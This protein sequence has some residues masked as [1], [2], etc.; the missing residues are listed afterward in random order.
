[1]KPARSSGINLTLTDSF[2]VATA[3]L[4]ECQALL[5]NDIT[6]KRVTELDIIVLDEL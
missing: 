5:T 2:Q 3:L 1:M 6:L 4:A